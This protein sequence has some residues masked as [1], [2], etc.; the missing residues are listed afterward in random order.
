MAT[1]SVRYIVT[2]MEEAIAFYRD[3]LG[4]EVDFHPAPGFARLK[5]GD[6]ALLLNAPGSGGAGATTEGGRPEPGGWSR[7]QL[8]SGD[9][10]A[11]AERFRAAGVRTRT[12]I[13]EGMGGRQMLIEDPSGN[14]VEL[15]EPA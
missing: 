7:F 10:D 15:F 4:F 3:V 13:V 11:D 12:G 8:V 9:L 1:V 6:L 2:A 5:K 14:P